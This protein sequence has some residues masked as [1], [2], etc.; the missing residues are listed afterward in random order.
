MGNDTPNGG[1]SQG[2]ENDLV[3]KRAEENNDLLTFAVQELKKTI[4]EQLTEYEY[5]KI[6]IVV[7]NIAAKIAE[8]APTME[9]LLSN[10]AL[11]GIR[12]Y[13]GKA[14]VITDILEDWKD[15]DSWPRPSNTG[16]WTEASCELIILRYCR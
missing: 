13:V 15:G 9:E 5:L 7:T 11:T 1:D 3:K 4:P 14:L 8:K 12:W 10:P 2:Q 6:G 16:P